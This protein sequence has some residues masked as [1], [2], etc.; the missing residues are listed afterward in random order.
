MSLFSHFASSTF[1]RSL[2]F[3]LISPDGSFSDRK[4]ATMKQRT[5]ANYETPFGHSEAST[6]DV[7]QNNRQLWTLGHSNRYLNHPLEHSLTYTG[8]Y[9]YQQ[10]SSLREKIGGT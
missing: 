2:R 7:R 10:K 1:S 5:S 6:V 3:L 4:Q 8:E 9:S